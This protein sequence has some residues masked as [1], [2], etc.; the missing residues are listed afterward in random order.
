MGTLQKRAQLLRDLIASFI[1]DQTG[2]QHDALFRACR[3]SIAFHSFLDTN[4]KTVENEWKSIKERLEDSAQFDKSQALVILLDRLR[5]TDIP[6]PHQQHQLHARI[7][8]FL[9]SSSRNPLKTRL[10]PTLIP[11][12]TRTHQDQHHTTA[13]YD[14]DDWTDSSGSDAEW[15][16]RDDITYSSDDTLSDWSTADHDD[17]A[18]RQ[19]LSRT[20]HRHDEEGGNGSGEFLDERMTAA[21]AADDDV[22]LTRLHTPS[23]R[24]TFKQQQRQHGSPSSHRRRR[25]FLRS[26]ANNTFGASLWSEKKLYAGHSSS[27]LGQSLYDATSLSVWLAARESSGHPARHLDPRKCYLEGEILVEV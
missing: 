1:P 22:S 9:I 11:R 21:A 18:D 27:S 20:S 4:E 8:S 25:K 16:R 17:Y 2:Q 14:I 15:W 6:S 26:T 12:L 24:S 5:S 10:D 23:R 7:V 19:Q 13:P 3:E